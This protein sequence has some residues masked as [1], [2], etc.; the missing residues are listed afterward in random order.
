M[1]LDKV[2][3]DLNNSRMIDMASAPDPNT[4]TALAATLWLKSNNRYKPLTWFP[5]PL[6][7][8]ISRIAD[9]A[10]QLCSYSLLS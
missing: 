1:N 10:I 5:L 4:I 3:Y 6:P 8:K 9:D 2:S 7:P